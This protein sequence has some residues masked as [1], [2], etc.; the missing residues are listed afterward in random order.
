MSGFNLNSMFSEE[1]IKNRSKNVQVVEIDITKI[2]SNFQNFYPIV[3]QENSNEFEAL[4]V[5]ID[6]EGLL[7]PILV[8]KSDDGS[9]RVLSGHRRLEAHRLLGKD[10]IGAIIDSSD[11]HNPDEEQIRIISANIQREKTPEIIKSEVQKLS[12]I[13][14]TYK[15]N[16][17]VP[18]GTLK[19]DWIGLKIGRTGRT[20]Q[21]YLSPITSL[22]EKE[23]QTTL[24][25]KPQKIEKTYAQKEND[26]LISISNSIS[27]LDDKLGEYSISDQE[28]KDLRGSLEY[29]QNK[30]GEILNNHF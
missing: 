27:K 7:S 21:K 30:I 29:I 20:V 17:L 8:L 10:T 26:K 28:E 23:E 16:G 22:E 24:F 12:V 5:S 4:K 9:Y 13:F 11:A 6:K 3:S 25:E 2:E 14:D 15:A 1:T 18:E 19:R